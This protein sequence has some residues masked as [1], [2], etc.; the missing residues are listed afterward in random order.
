MPSEFMCS[1]RVSCQTGFKTHQYTILSQLLDRIG[2]GDVDG[3]L[4]GGDWGRE[5]GVGACCSSGDAVSG[6]KY[7]IERLAVTDMN[8]S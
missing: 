5:L 2:L 3:A 8:K 7:E 6:N 1:R 4:G